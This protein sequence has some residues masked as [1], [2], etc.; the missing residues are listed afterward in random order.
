MYSTPDENCRWDA[1]SKVE[2]EALALEAPCECS[3]SWLVI[4]AA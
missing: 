2:A 4:V 3:M 1:V